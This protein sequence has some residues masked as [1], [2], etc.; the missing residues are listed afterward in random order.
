M[1]IDRRIE[2]LKKLIPSATGERL[3]ELTEQLSFLLKKKQDEEEA[4]QRTSQVET[5]EPPLEE[6]P[7]LPIIENL[8]GITR[9]EINSKDLADLY[10]DSDG[11]Q[12]FMNQ[13][14]E[15]IMNKFAKD[16]LVLKLIKVKCYVQVKVTFEFF[17]NKPYEPTFK[18]LKRPF[19]FDKL[20]QRS[21]LVQSV[22]EFKSVIVNQTRD[23]LR[24]NDK[25]ENNGSGWVIV[26]PVAFKIRFIKYNDIF[27]RA[28][29]FIPTPSWLHGRRAVINFRNEDDYCFV[30]CI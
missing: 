19:Y 16:E 24:M 26:R 1:D 2:A 30:K 10:I 18:T 3:F 8:K 20:I 21:N 13:C 14:V 25:F 9:L 22:D 12:H 4:R 15:Y 7:S 5:I 11:V 27:R 17:H 29:G 28:R 23:I 6:V